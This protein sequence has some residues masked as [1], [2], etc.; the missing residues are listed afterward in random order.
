MEETGSKKI[1]VLGSDDKRQITA[2]LASTFSGKLFRL[3]IIYQGLAM[4]VTPK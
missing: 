1:K 3:E 2:L 4:H